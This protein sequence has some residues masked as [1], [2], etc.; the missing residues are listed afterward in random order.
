M[1]MSGVGVIVL[2]IIFGFIIFGG[3]VTLILR[4]FQK[5]EQGKA[6]IVNTMRVVPVVTFTGRVVLPVIHKA[7]IMDISLKTIEIRRRGSEGL[8][9]K[10]NIRADIDVKFYVRVNPTAEDVIRVAQS[11]GCARASDRETLEEL[12]NAKFSEALKTVGREMEF[13]DLYKERIVFRDKIIKAIGQDLLNGYVLED[14]AIDFLEQTP[15]GSMDPRNILDAQGITKITE[16]TAEQHINT[17]NFRRQ[18]EERIASRDAEARERILEQERRKADAEA[19]QKREIRNV[20]DREQAEI[21]TIASQEKLRSEQARLHTEEHVAILQQNKQRE[22][23]VAEQN[24]LKVV[25]METERV[26]LARELEVIKREREIE[27]GRIEKDKSVEQEKREIADVIRE[28][29]AVEKTVAE[30]EERIKE[31]RAVREA[32]RDKQVRILNAEARAQEAFVTDIKKAEAGKQAA[33]HRAREKI[34][35]AEGERDAADKSAAAKIRMAEG[36]RAEASAAGLA[37]VEV[38]QANATAIEKEGEAK[39]H[40]LEEEM[41]A[42]AMGEEQQGLAKVRV[43]QAEADAEEKMGMVQ[44][45]I[46]EAETSVIEKR[47][48]AEA[49]SREDYLLA[50]ASGLAEKFKAMDALSEAGR[51]HEEFRL[52]LEQ[53]LKV[54]EAAIQAQTTIAEKQAVALAEAFKQTKIDIVGGDHQ[55]FERMINSLS[56]AKS[57]DGFVRQSDTAQHLFQDYL[58]GEAN[59]IEDIRQILS[60]PAISSEDIK[61]MS[62]SAFLAKLIS[63]ADDPEQKNRLGTLLKWVNKAGLSEIKPDELGSGHA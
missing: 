4:F 47:G 2:S 58:E 38:K 9:C 50:E 24:R 16:I 40:A 39:A 36:T 21:D 56:F 7:E 44:I 8:I 11:I 46:Q 61:N 15:I 3:I 31:V 26:N 63:A 45:K 57:I 19:K 60:N 12:F 41:R 20:Q 52:N 55:F 1:E 17:N 32:E 62:L 37:E 5:V 51:K 49:K 43:R 53:Q 33:E 13:Q 6:L 42:R 18:E 30:E 27:L 35:L 25:G 29:I 14:A 10:D 48:A 59:I 28:R 22:A 23:E 34:I 54:R